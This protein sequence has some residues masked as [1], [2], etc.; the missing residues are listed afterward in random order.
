AAGAGGEEQTLFFG[1]WYIHTFRRTAKGWRIASLYEKKCYAH[2]LPEYITAQ[3][4]SSAKKSIISLKEVVM[5]C[6]SGERV[7]TWMMETGSFYIWGILALATLVLSLKNRRIPLMGLCLIAGTS[8]FWQEFF[9]DWGAYLAWNPAFARLPFWGEMAYTTP[10]KPLFMPFSWGW[11]FS[12][13]IPLL[14]S[15][16]AFLGRKFPKISMTIWSFSIASPLFFAYQLYVEGSSV[17]NGW[18]TYDVVVGPALSSEK[19]NLPIIFPILIGLWAG[20]F[21]A[22]L[23]RDRKSTRL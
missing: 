5:Q 11:W 1:L 15:L 2:N 8:A 19:G 17:A 23:A 7:N 18:W 4:A 3:P 13:S 9:G 14:V 20:L 6:A 10:V 16:V 21:V 12:I 22:M